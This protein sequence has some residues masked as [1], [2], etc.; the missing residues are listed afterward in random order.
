[1]AS[2][3]VDIQILDIR[4][5]LVKE[6]TGNG[7]ISATAFSPDEKFLV[8]ADFTGLVRIIDVATGDDVVQLQ[9][10]GVVNSIAFSSD[11]KYVAATS[12][13]GTNENPPADEGPLLHVWLLRPK[14]LI[15]EAC[16]RLTELQSTDNQMRYCNVHTELTP[17]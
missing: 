5:R 9:P 17:H 6:V 3:G 2:F 11:G 7:E 16:Q 4:T 8:I 1:M 14:D 12:G 15:K 10:E 13:P